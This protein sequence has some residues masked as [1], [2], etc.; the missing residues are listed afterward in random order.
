MIKMMRVTLLCLLCTAALFGQHE[1]ETYADGRIYIKLKNDI[2]LSLS[3]YGDQKNVDVTAY[4]SL[5][6][7]IEKYEVK[8]I[9]RPF[10]AAKGSADLQ[11]TFELELAHDKDVNA[12]LNELKTSNILDYVERVPLFRTHATPNDPSYSSQWE[13]AKI[14]AS[15]AWNYSTGSSSI[16]VAI[17][18]E[19]VELT[20]PDLAA[21]IW[22]NPGEIAGNSIDDD[23]NGYVDDV[24]GFD[25]ANNDNNP[26][27]TTSAFTHGT[28][29]AGMASARSN[30]GL[31]IASI[32]YS[33]KIIAIQGS[34]NAGIM[35]YG[36][37]GIIYAVAAKAK[38]I[39]CSWG[40]T[41]SSV[42]GQNVIDYAYNSGCIIVASAGNAGN[43]T[44]EYPAA[45]N[46]VIAVSSTGSGD[47]KSS[48]SSYG[49]YVDLSAPGEGV[50]TT[51]V[52]GGYGYTNGTS[53]SSPMVAGLCGLML[54]LNPTLT[55]ADVENCLKTNTD[56][57]DTQNPSYIGQLGSGR[58][59]ADKAM[60]CVAATLLLKPTTDFIANFTTVTAGG[61]VTFTDK[62]IHNPTSWTW[63]FTGGTPGSFS[64]KTPPAITYS[65]P[66]T[67]DVTLVTNNANGPD[68]KLKTGYITVTAASGC[69]YVNLSKTTGATP[70][71]HGVY[72]YADRKLP[73]DSGYMIGLNGFD[74]DNQ[75]A[76]Y[77]DASTSP[78]NQLT[79]VF[80]RFVKAN[81]SVP[82]NLSKV[83]TFKVYDGTSGVPGALL[84][85]ATKTLQQVKTATAANKYLDIAFR[86]V[87]NLPVSKKFFIGFDYGTLDWHT[88]TLAMISN[89]GGETNP[90]GIWEQRNNTWGQMGVTIGTW[91]FNG[92]MYAFPAL[93]NQPVIATSVVSPTTICEGGTVSMNAAGSTFQ[94]TLLWFSPGGNPTI[95]NSISQSVLY[96]TAGNY[97]AKLYV[98]GGG[99][100]EVDST[101]NIITV[102]ATPNISITSSNGTTIC[103][104]S[105]TLLTASGAAGS[106]TWTPPT[107]LTTTSGPVT[108]AN[109]SSD[110][111]YSVSGTTAGCVGTSAINI[112]VDQPIVPNVTVNPSNA[113]V[114]TVTPIVFNASASTNVSSYT[115]SFPGGTPSSSNSSSPSVTYATMGTY[116]V[117]LIE[118]NSCTTNNT[119]SK[120]VTVGCV[121]V[122]ELFSSAN[123]NTNYNSL[124]KQLNITVNDNFNMHDNLAVKLI[125]MVGQ[126]VYTGQLVTAGSA[127]STVIDMS[128]YANGIYTVQLSGS[129][130][131]YNRKFVAE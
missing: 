95:S 105:S 103:P 32:G 93:T 27:P 84:G 102:N 68:T 57:I 66:G 92:S 3:L 38:V 104:G 20:H 6:S 28:M 94:D 86:P 111:N 64:G 127:S 87:I 113:S 81:T 75:K 70:A 59:N 58:I 74:N 121:G 76:Q 48:W 8:K 61:K 19:G 12:V 89:T 63:T 4:P 10:A 77:Y 56:N 16:T 131:V 45:Y 100:H 73:V 14:S 41:V 39:N 82:A 78:Y 50:Y 65:T 130:G 37:D 5:K 21:N 26:N 101:T 22:V 71:W 79:R 53:F 36:Y 52:G 119:Y 55:E 129:S 1:N 62:T 83:I 15:A 107:N 60:Q 112:K 115:W 69:D 91:G 99:C 123:V 98:V 47:A 88:D 17:V 116:T 108:T 80:F 72:Y 9:S 46:H 128:S 97:I 40:G 13:L 118:A 44:P 49:S 33:V 35:S 29:V 96:N 51:M 67:Y 42:T 124:Y 31:G 85:S 126:V 2:P 24:N 34:V 125:D 120:V 110:I 54:S 114:C 106:Y 11:H 23:N 90:S 7:I 43:S 18:D 122:K 117:T 25:V 30:N 109:P